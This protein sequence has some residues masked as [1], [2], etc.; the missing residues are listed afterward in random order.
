MKTVDTE[1][2]Y[3]KNNPTGF[4]RLLQIAGTK[5]WWLFASMFL[6]V[7]AT[8]AQFVPTITVYL[9]IKELAA[10]AADL[11]SV[12][13][14]MLYRLAFISLG[15]VAAFGV[16]LYCSSMLSHIAA[17]NILYRLRV[18]VAEKLTRLSMGY[19][20]RTASGKIKKIMGEDVERIELYVA[21]HI[22]DITTAVLFPSLVVVFLFVMDWRLAIAAFIP[23]PLVF[24]L[25]FLWMAGG[26]AKKGFQ[27][28]HNALEKMNAAVVEYVRGMPV[29][30][31]FGSA[32]DS[33]RKLTESVSF[34][35]TWSQKMNKD[36]SSTY[37]AFL[38]AA[39]SSLVFIVPLSVILL[40]NT[41]V[42]SQLIPTILLFTIVGSGFFF[43][44]LKLMFMAG[45]LQQ[46]NLGVDRID[47]ILY[48]EE[49]KEHDSGLDPADNS[50]V[51]KNVCFTYDKVEVLKEVSFRAEPGEITALVGPSGAGKSTIGLLAARF[52]DVNAGR[53]LIGGIDIR[54][55]S[56]E[57][58]M[59]HVSFVFQDTFLFF[60]TIEENIRMG[61]SAAS[62]E[63][64][65]AAAKAAQCHEFIERLPQGYR[66]MVGEGGTYLSGGEQ[67]RIAIA[68]AIL[69]NAPIVILDEATAYTD[70]ENEGKILEGLSRLIEGKTVLII[71]HRL[72]TI[73]TA[74]KILVVNDGRIAETGTH[75]KL[76]AK[77]GL[78]N[79]MWETYSRAREWKINPG[80]LS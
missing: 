79:S 30:R 7:I 71:A 42:H 16:L 80:A 37:P 22:P 10:H 29:F 54:K 36:Y 72:S 73:K 46:I 17:F 33:F 44:L 65:V 26:K 68:R 32:G 11:A 19:F 45:M 40:K 31:I 3:N 78:Y 55:M 77:R 63:D 66:T 70:P 28:Y 62:K 38:T 12:D 24:G 20:S 74:D 51:F 34:Y 67:Q 15:S 1:K 76:N 57:R 43:P 56:N 53:I 61:N 4:L 14:G 64:V 35:N 52:W 60:D 58:L 27:E 59:H 8:V 48:H 23:F 50:I 41:S 49:M 5:K 75:E 25:I 9:I 39:S 69:K 2:T 13:K 18:T 21:H 47:S 6:A